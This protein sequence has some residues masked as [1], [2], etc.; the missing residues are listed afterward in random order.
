MEKE[1]NACLVCQRNDEQ[2]P[3][4]QITY[5][6]NPLWIC[7]EHMPILIHN[8]DKLMAMLEQQG[9]NG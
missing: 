8:T 1:K 6:G 7:P 3:L 5:K 2:V 4:I 9:N